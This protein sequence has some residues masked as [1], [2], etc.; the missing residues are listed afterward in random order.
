MLFK[1]HKT[2][3]ILFK[4]LT[5]LSITL[6]LMLISYVDLKAQTLE[7][8][9]VEEL[10]SALID[11]IN[12]L[13]TLSIAEKEVLSLLVITLPEKG[14]SSSN[15]ELETWISD[16]LEFFETLI[17]EERT[18]LEQLT[19]EYF[20]YANTGNNPTLSKLQSIYHLI[21]VSNNKL[22]DYSNK[23]RA[24]EGKNEPAPYPP[25][26]PNPE[27]MLERGG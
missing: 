8:S 21:Q 12:T 6:I 3:I 27:R 24:F 26:P 19:K 11:K 7:Q 17:Q 16:P 10:T 2:N 1:T 23:K 5:V 9:S 15:L 4:K 25:M 14:F 13:E 18:K 22:G 20:E